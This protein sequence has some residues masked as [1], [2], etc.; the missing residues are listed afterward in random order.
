MD[1]SVLLLRDA[2]KSGERCSVLNYFDFRRQSDMT[3]P[4]CYFGG[5]KNSLDLSFSLLFSFGER[6]VMGQTSSIKIVS[7]SALAILRNLRRSQGPLRFGRQV[8]K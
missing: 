7:L 6:Q 1:H 2:P 4:L 5:S 3:E 8:G